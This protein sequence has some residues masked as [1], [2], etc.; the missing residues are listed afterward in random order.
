VSVIDVYDVV[1]DVG[2][3]CARVIRLICVSDGC[4][5]VRPLVRAILGGVE[6]CVWR[7]DVDRPLGC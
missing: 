5:C 3:W 2:G 7:Y 4:G 1:C 6:G